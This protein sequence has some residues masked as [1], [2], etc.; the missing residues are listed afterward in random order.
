[1]KS[2]SGKGKMVLRRKQTPRE[3]AGGCLPDQY[4]PQQGQWPRLGSCSELPSKRNKRRNQHWATSPGT[5]FILRL[6]ISACNINNLTQLQSIA[7]R[8]ASFIFGVIIDVMT[9]NPGLE[10]IKGVSMNTL[11][12]LGLVKVTSDGFPLFPKEWHPG[13]MQSVRVFLLTS[14]GFGVNA[15][16]GWV[17]LGFLALSYAGL[18]LYLKSSTVW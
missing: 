15:N 16:G 14:L 17:G 4:R 11:S 10:T 13:P 12:K 3:K 5:L 9:R 6:E 7:K 8:H 1:M 18:H 2:Q